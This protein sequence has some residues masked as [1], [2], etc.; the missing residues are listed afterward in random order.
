MEKTEIDPTK[1]NYCG[2]CEPADESVD[3]KERKFCGAESTEGPGTCTDHYCGVNKEGSAKVNYCFYDENKDE[4]KTVCK[5][6]LKDPI[7]PEDDFLACGKCEE[8]PSMA[9]SPAVTVSPSISSAPSLSLQP[10][11]DPSEFP[12]SMPSNDSI[13]LFERIDYQDFED[14]N[15]GDY[16]VSDPNFNQEAKLSDKFKDVNGQDTVGIKLK[17]DA[18]VYTNPSISTASYS[19]IKIEFLV[20]FKNM[21]WA[22][23][24]SFWVEYKRDGNCNDLSSWT[25]MMS[26]GEGLSDEG[27]LFTNKLWYEISREVDVS[28]ASDIC[29]RLRMI[30][31]TFDKDTKTETRIDN[32]EI[33]GAS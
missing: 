10:S 22:E 29:L 7:K 32:L 14:K 9:P 25:P 18:A 12:S 30:D 21:L 11:Q 33:L 4:F 1:V 16:W 23:K 31:L 24:D 2:C 5:E 13:L 8:M 3:A 19:V 27:S 28:G 20:L 15:W 26:V 6:P 17:K